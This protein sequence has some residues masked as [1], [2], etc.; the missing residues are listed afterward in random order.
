MANQKEFFNPD[1]KAKTSQ[2]IIEK[3]KENCNRYSEIM[4][5]YKELKAL[6]GN[7][8]KEEIIAIGTNFL[9]KQI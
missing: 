7:K 6:A 9:I 4:A 2:E 3:A 5:A 1:E 8:N